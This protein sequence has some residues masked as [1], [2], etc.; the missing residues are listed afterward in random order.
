MNIAV[1]EH[2]FADA[3]AQASALAEAVA[4]QLRDALAER[5]AAWLAVPGGQTPWQFLEALAQHALDWPRVN[6]TMTD[7][8]LVPMDDARSNS[9]LLRE[10]PIGRVPARFVPLAVG[11]GDRAD[12]AALEKQLPQR[13]DAVVL[14]MGTDGHCASLYPDADVIAAALRV[15]AGERLMRMHTPS[16]PEPRVTLTLPQLTA[17]RALYLLIRGAAK[18]ATLDAALHGTAPFA[19]APIRA[20][21]AHAPAVPQIFWCP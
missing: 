14:G 19:Q 1:A 13:F 17:T 10:S 2:K 16:V 3:N 4:M 5:D 6:I 8:R 12:L 15:D 11:Q 9:R 21:L 7:E 18:Q 20:V